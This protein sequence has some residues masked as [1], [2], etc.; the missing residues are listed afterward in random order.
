M[1]LD[2]AGLRIEGGDLADLVARLVSES[3][4][5]V[6]TVRRLPPRAARTVPIPDTVDGRLAEALRGRGIGELYT[7][8]AQVLEALRKGGHVVVVTPTASGK[9][10]CYNLP[11]LETLLHEPS[12]RALYLFPTKALAQD[13]LAELEELARVLP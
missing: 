5:A 6:T 13:Q 4:A 12:A 2:M 3:G 8:Q 11:V 10:L 7:H 9:T 1:A